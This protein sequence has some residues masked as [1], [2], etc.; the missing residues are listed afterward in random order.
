MSL[1]LTYPYD[2]NSAFSFLRVV[3]RRIFTDNVVQ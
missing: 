2:T 3:S 1:I